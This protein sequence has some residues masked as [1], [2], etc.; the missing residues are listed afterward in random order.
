MRNIVILICISFVFANGQLWA[1]VQADSTMNAI[2]DYTYQTAEHTAKGAYDHW[3][4][5]I[6]VFA[7][8]VGAITLGFTYLTYKS[9]KKTEVNTRRWNSKQERTNLRYMFLKLMD[10]AS[11]L[12]FLECKRVESRGE[13][14]PELSVLEELLLDEKELHADEYFGEGVNYNM[15]QDLRRGVIRYNSVIKNKI[16]RLQCLNDDYASPMAKFYCDCIE[17]CYELIRSFLETYDYMFTTD[18]MNQLR[19]FEMNDD[20]RECPLPVVSDLALYRYIKKVIPT[21]SRFQKEL[22]CLRNNYR[23]LVEYCLKLKNGKTI[24]TLQEEYKVDFLYYFREADKVVD[25]SLLFPYML[26][27]YADICQ[28]FN[29][30]GLIPDNKQG[31]YPNVDSV[32]NRGRRYNYQLV[33]GINAYSDGCRCPR[34]LE[35]AVS[36]IRNVFTS[37]SLTLVVLQQILIDDYKNSLRKF[38]LLEKQKTD[39]SEGIPQIYTPADGGTCYYNVHDNIFEKVACGK[40]EMFY[41]PLHGYR[42]SISKGEGYYG[43]F[44]QEMLDQ[45]GEVQLTKDV[46]LEHLNKVSKLILTN[47]REHI[48]HTLEC[49]VLLEGVR[50]ESGISRYVD[51]WVILKIVSVDKYRRTIKK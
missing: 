28:Y 6:S 7:F 46:P 15:L 35:P 36:I 10:A 13:F 31:V 4:L 26:K 48:L 11:V 32:E 20:L 51:H 30:E 22:G 39:Y 1:A 27:V 23:D 25:V 16:H 38:E 45:Y 34:E 17:S 37:F 33:P 19:D 8:I 50:E 41:I 42:I 14:V 5:G 18:D 29:Q 21:N 49:T 40:E 44:K 24:T 12:S 9:Q 3:A 2:K 43:L 47:N